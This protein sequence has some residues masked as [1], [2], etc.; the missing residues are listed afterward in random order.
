MAAA[1]Q[2]DE[3]IVL[4]YSADF[5]RPLAVCVAEA[6][7]DMLRIRL[8]TIHKLCELYE[9]KATCQRSVHDHCQV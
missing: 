1:A 3:L 8:D 9:L 2:E 5:N 4:H 7:T 6:H